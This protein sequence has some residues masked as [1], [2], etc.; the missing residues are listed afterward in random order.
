MVR[1]LQSSIKIIQSFV[2]YFAIENSNDVIFNIFIVSRCESGLYVISYFL[3]RFLL[4]CQGAV[5]RFARCQF[6]LGFKN[7]FYKIVIENL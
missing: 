7:Q 2:F 6:N 4:R 5:N 1:R 3:F